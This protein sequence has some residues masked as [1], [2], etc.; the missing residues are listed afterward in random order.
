MCLLRARDLSC[1]TFSLYVN[2]C[3]FPFEVLHHRSAHFLHLGADC[4]SLSSTTGYSG[5]SGRGG[6][7]WARKMNCCQGNLPV[8]AKE[9]G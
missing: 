9:K 3:N 7:C 8:G 2:I 1:V 4:F 6:G 5:G